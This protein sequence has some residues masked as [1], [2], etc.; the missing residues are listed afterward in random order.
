MS[1]KDDEPIT[2]SWQLAVQLNRNVAAL[3]EVNFKAVV[4]QFLGDVSDKVFVFLQAGKLVDDC[5]CGIPRA[6]R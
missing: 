2:I 6:I 3:V 1:P 5:C 4:L